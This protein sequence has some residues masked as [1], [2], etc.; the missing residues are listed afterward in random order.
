[1]RAHLGFLLLVFLMLVASTYSAIPAGEIAT[2]FFSDSGSSKGTVFIRTNTTYAGEPQYFVVYSGATGKISYEPEKVF[3]FFDD[4]NGTALNTTKWQIS[5]GVSATVSSDV[6][7]IHSTG[8]NGYLYSTSSYPFDGGFFVRFYDEDGSNFIGFGLIYSPYTGICGRSFYIQYGQVYWKDGNGC[9][10]EGAITD[11][12]SNKYFEHYT[13]DESGSFV[14]IDGSIVAQTTNNPDPTTGE[15][16]FYIPSGR[17]AGDLVVDYVAVL[18]NNT[19]TSATI[20]AIAEETGSYSL[21]GHT[22]TKRTVYRITPDE[23]G[24]KTAILH[25]NDTGI[26]VT[27]LTNL[28][29]L[30]GGG[31]GDYTFANFDVQIIVPRDNDV[32]SSPVYEIFFKADYAGDTSSHPMTCQ[33]VVEYILDPELSAVARKFYTIYKDFTYSPGKT[34]K[35]TVPAEVSAIGLNDEYFSDRPRVQKVNL[36][37]GLKDVRFADFDTVDIYAVYPD[38]FGMALFVLGVMFGVLSLL[39]MLYTDYSLIGAVSSLVLLTA[40]ALFSPE[41][42][43]GVI[44]QHMAVVVVIFDTI[45]V[46]LMLFKVVFEKGEEARRGL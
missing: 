42:L 18:T 17:T 28:S 11:P 8:T 16:A 30:P 1:M 44:H 20:E 25:L 39:L 38:Y 23:T 45:V 37:C 32:I 46:V 6:L 33:A 15:V 7:R 27:R 31:W 9:G 29:S 36:Y 10:S 35:M 21:Y 24:N 19:Y 14:R 41:T 26:A 34:Y 43:S 40:V 22:F 4:F 2:P 3:D 12:Y 13:F 5:G